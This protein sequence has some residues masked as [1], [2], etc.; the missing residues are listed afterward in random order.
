MVRDRYEG[1]LVGVQQLAVPSMITRAIERSWQRT[2]KSVRRGN[3]GV[4]SVLELT[5]GWYS[6]SLLSPPRNWGFAPQGRS[7]SVARSPLLAYTDTSPA[8]YRWHLVPAGAR[9]AQ[10]SPRKGEIIAAL[11]CAAE[12]LH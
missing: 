9:C 1:K 3:E 2:M 12:K 7:T 5:L 4:T 10:G 11:P 8:I 6:T